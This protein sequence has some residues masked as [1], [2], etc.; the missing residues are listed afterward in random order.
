MTAL[1]MLRAQADL[2]AYLKA[3]V[4]SQ[5]IAVNATG[6]LTI[7]LLSD[8]TTYSDAPMLAQQETPALFVIPS[9][10]GYRGTQWDANLDEQH[11]LEIG[12][13]VGDQDEHNA[14]QALLGY[15]QAVLNAVGL[16]PRRLAAM[17]HG[18]QLLFGAVGATAEDVVKYTNIALEAP[19]PFYSQATIPV[20]VYMSE[21]PS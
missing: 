21:V 14:L 7:P 19:V 11:G 1:G 13:E 8:M 4:P 3:N 6:V 5:I 18:E 12:I 17:A 2:L 16:W 15:T 10:S 20:T 9:A